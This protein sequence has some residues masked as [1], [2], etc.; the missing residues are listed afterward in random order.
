MVLNTKATNDRHD[1]PARD[2]LIAATGFVVLYAALF[3]HVPKLVSCELAVMAVGCVMVGVLPAETRRVSWGLFPLLAQAPL[4]STALDFYVGYPLRL[5]ATK[6]AA[7]MLLGNVAAVGT[8]LST[9]GNV[10]FVDAPCSGIRMLSA[11]LVLAGALSLLLR[12]RLIPTFALLASSVLLALFGNAHRAASLVLVNI[13]PDAPA[14]ALIGIVVFAECS[15]LLLLIAKFLHRRQTRRISPEGV[16]SKAGPLVKLTFLLACAATA[17]LTMLPGG[18]PAATA[19]TTTVAWPKTW[20]GQ[21]LSP[22][23]LPSEWDSFL[24]GFPGAWAQF[25]VGDTGKV[26]LMRYCT[27]ATRMLH[28]AEN[29]YLALGGDCTPMPSLRDEQGHVWSRFEY[30]APDG[31]KRTVS[32][33]YFALSEI[34][35]SRQLPARVDDVSDWL[36]SATSWSDASAWYWASSMPGSDVRATLAITVAEPTHTGG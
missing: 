19:S 9:G 23:P 34:D 28:P 35:T 12:F 26:V 24:S 11:S 29:C 32:Q 15:V 7:V 22:I 6:L 20:Q 21:T 17:G 18:I 36:R 13:P 4:V 25:R 14:H 31:A 2:W 30:T 1:A 27:I 33:C 10:V 16:A 8:G 3:P 5:C